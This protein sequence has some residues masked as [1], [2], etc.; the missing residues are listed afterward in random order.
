MSTT[1]TNS[2]A[3]VPVFEVADATYRYREVTALNH[4][5]LTVQAGRRVALLG[6]NG[7]GKSTLLR[8]LD[9]LCFPDEGTVR[10]CGRMLTEEG[11]Q[12]D[13]FGADFR[14]RVGLVFQ[15]PDVQL[16]SPTVFDEMA[17][18]P[19]QLRWPPDQVRRK[20]AETLEMMEISHLKDRSPHHLSMGEKKR[21]ALASVLV[22]DPEILLLDEP[23]S[24]LD[25]RSSSHM[26][27]F[28]VRAKG[29]ARTIVTTTHDL[30][31]IEDVADDCI[32]IHEGRIA[33][34]GTP[35]QILGDVA[36][37]K[38]AGLLHSHLHVHKSGE[39]HTHSHL[40]RHEH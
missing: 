6:A 39:I 13:G 19:L 3:P 4:L 5:S 31:I 18:G 17:F 30:D 16:F 32:V 8:M 15:N 40:H 33:A 26:I 1:I 20:I 38:T 24:M 7:S 9:G 23:T 2:G 25:P 29:D 35:G 14:R 21:V 36:S 28:L 27:D 12:N 34:S 10:F 11:I 22:L 37:L